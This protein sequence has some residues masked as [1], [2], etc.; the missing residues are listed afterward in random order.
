MDEH[1]IRETLSLLLD[2]D[3]S[4]LDR[5]A[6]L[7]EQG[8][9]SLLLLRLLERINRHLATR[10]NY[11]QL[12]ENPTIEAWCTQFHLAQNRAQASGSGNPVSQ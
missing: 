5:Q 9:H 3:V 8:L 11:H 1:W 6:N 12:A 7:I 4:Q 10:V 2:E